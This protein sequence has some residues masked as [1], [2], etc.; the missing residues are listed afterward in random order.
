MI[1]KC[2]L[3]FRYIIHTY[4]ALLLKCT[5]PK[6]LCFS[7]DLKLG[8]DVVLLRGTL[9]SK[10]FS[11][12]IKIG[13]DREGVIF[14]HVK[15]GRISN[16]CNYCTFLLD[17]KFGISTFKALQDRRLFLFLRNWIE[18]QLDTLSTIV[19]IRT[20]TPENVS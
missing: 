6:I 18:H 9:T 13:K 17:A 19:A 15:I 7:I 4:G 20:L 1:I 16:A 10:N 2:K 12:W 3:W 11:N 5:Q 8:Q 14:S